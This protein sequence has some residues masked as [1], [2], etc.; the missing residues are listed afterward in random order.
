MLGVLTALLSGS[1]EMDAAR[2][3]SLL[4]VAPTAS[5]AI[6][7]PL[8][9][10]EKCRVIQLGWPFG[11]RKGVWGQE[12]RSISSACPPVQNSMSRPLPNSAQGRQ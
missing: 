7:A 3:L 6:G 12:G 8:F 5:L 4:V 9:F 1:N 2:L 11:G 10:N